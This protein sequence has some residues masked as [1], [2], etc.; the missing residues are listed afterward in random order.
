VTSPLSHS[1]K[2]QTSRRE[3]LAA[4]VHCAGGIALASTVRAAVASKLEQAAP[5]VYIRRGIDEDATVANGGAIANIGFIVGENSV[6]V[7]DPGG[8]LRDGRQLR[9]SIRAITKLPIRFVVLS[10]VHPDHIF[11]AGAFREDKPEFIGHF[12]LPNS[13]AQRGEYYRERLE[14]VLGKGQA[15]AVVAPT[16]LV[17]GEQ[18]IDLGGRKLTITAHPLAHTD[19]DLSV[20]DEQTGTLL[21]SDL[22][23]VRRVP[24]LDGSLKGWLKALAA[25]KQTKARRAVPGHGPASVDW[26]AGAGDLE[27]YLSVLL[28]ETREAVAKGVEIE[29]AVKTVGRSEREKWL[30]F[31]DYHGRNVT[32]AF[33][34][35][36]WE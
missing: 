17:Q 11:G 19:S 33:K 14:A 35:V 16:M 22:L 32:Q 6:A 30:L 5:G 31:D 25:L 27:R 24:S 1:A 15:G 26:P 28:R 7:M 20:L 18:A 36:E 10:H 29:A 4:C 21:A 8:S 13:L 3:F 9:A 2:A 34:E 12:R 23:F